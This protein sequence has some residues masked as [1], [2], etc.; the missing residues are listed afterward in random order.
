M[1]ARGRGDTRPPRVRHASGRRIEDVRSLRRSVRGVRR[2]GVGALPSVRGHPKCQLGCHVGCQLR[3]LCARRGVDPAHDVRAKDDEVLDTAQRRPAGQA[4]DVQAPPGVGLRRARGESRLRRE[5]RRPKPARRR[6]TRRRLP[7]VVRVL[8]RR[9]ARRVPDPHGAPGGRDA[10][11]RALV[12]RRITDEGPIAY[13]K[14]LSPFVAVDDDEHGPSRV[15]VERKTHHE[16][17]SQESSVKERFR[18]DARDLRSYL[19]GGVAAKSQTRDRTL[20][21]TLDAESATLAKEIA[22]TSCSPGV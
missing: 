3:R 7:R 8:R 20:D 10:R 11:P 1:P 5:R 9:R 19:A 18:L 6:G 21:Q 14:D 16:S 17:W 22:R 15:Y 2:R 12:R 13:Q 4:R